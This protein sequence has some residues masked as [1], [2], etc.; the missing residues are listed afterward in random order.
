MVLHKTLNQN[1][2]VHNGAK[3]TDMPHCIGLVG[4]L[5]KDYEDT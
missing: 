2:I 3:I 4:Y 5:K 1:M